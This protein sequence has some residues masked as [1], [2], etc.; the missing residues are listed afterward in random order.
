[1]KMYVKRL[2]QR[3]RTGSDFYDGNGYISPHLSDL[4]IEIIKDLLHTHK[5]ASKRLH[6]LTYP[7]FTE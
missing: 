1:M 3:K 2:Q 7:A 5:Y 4:H 6:V